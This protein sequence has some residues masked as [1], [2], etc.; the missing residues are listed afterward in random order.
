MP[1]DNPVLFL[2][3]TD[4]QRSRAFYEKIV[5]LT[6]VSED[7]FAVV[8][9]VGK[10]SLRIQKVAAKPE[11]GHTVLGW[12]VTD[13]DAEVQRLAKNGVEFSFYEGLDQEKNGVWHAP[14]GAKVAW[15]TD[16]DK[17]ILSLTEFR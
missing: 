9:K 12:K 17:N 8:F 4:A 5:R 2:A 6:F 10:L 14:S 13:I 1:L 3:T 15:F 7:A 16:P 11:V